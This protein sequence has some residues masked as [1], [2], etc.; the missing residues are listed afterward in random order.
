MPYHAPRRL[1]KS[2][3]YEIVF[4]SAASPTSPTMAPSVDDML[5][6]ALEDDAVDAQINQSDA[7]RYWASVSPDD[8]GVLGGYPHV[9]RVDLQGST[10]FLAKLRR[11][12]RVFGPATGAL[13]RVVD[14]GAGIGRVTKGFLGKVA[15]AVDVVEPVTQLTD[16][17]TQGE[18]F[19]ELRSRSVVGEVFNV[20]LEKWTPP[21]GR[22]YAVI[23][24]QWCVGQLT[25]RQLIT[26][27]RRIRGYVSNG[28]WIIV[29]E[30]MSTDPYG[31]D[32]F[33]GT[34]SSV[35]RSDGKFRQI[36]ERAGLRVIAHELQRGMPKD[37]YPVRTYALVVTSDEAIEEDEDE[38]DDEKP[39]PT[40]GEV[41]YRMVN[42]R[43]MRR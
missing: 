43:L 6:A 40:N 17:I 21:E 4:D 8:D 1:S 20:G 32:I 24:H 39:K 19:A 30:N 15:K 33:D 35:T 28:G 31:K 29:K 41:E 16:V 23:W 2:T 27:L 37:L 38:E 25:D 42:G 11:K 9:S 14:C 22:Q 5:D 12:S 7:L 18:E 26:Y 34:D 3:Q 10:A 13:P 36:F